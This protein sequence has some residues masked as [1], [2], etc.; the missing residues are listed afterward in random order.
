MF[1]SFSLLAQSSDSVQEDQPLAF[2]KHKLELATELQDGLAKLRVGENNNDLE[3][4]LAACLE[5]ANLYEREKYFAKELTFL[6]QAGFIANE[7]GK[8]EERLEIQTKIA[9]S[10]FAN[11]EWE[12]A[13]DQSEELF[14]QHQIFGQYQPAIN[15]LEKMAESAIKL[16]NYVKAREIYL[17]IMEIAGVVG[18]KPVELTALNNM[19]FASTH[20]EN[21]KEAIHYFN[22][23]EIKTEEDQIKTPGYVFTN[24]GIAWNNLGERDKALKKLR[25]AEKQDSERK[26][27]IQHLIASIYLTDNDIYN[28]LT[29]NELAIESAKK[30]DDK[31][32]MADAY[33]MASQIYQELYEHDK[34][35]D[36]Y[37]K[38]LSLKDSLERVLILEQK[39]LENIHVFMDDTENNIRQSIVESEL[40]QANLEQAEKQNEVIQLQL[41]KE[42]QD[43]EQQRQ[44][45]QIALL[46]K[47]QEAKEASIRT[48][49]LEAD[50]TRQ[51]LALATQTNLAL[52]REQ[53]IEALNQQ[54]QLDSLEAVKRAQAQQQEFEL[55]EKQKEVERQEK[56]QQEFRQ[57]MYT[58]GGL[59][60]LIMAIITGSW[61]YARKLNRELA[62]QNEKI[63]LQ[64]KEIVSERNRAE[65]LLLNILPAAIA[66]ELKEKGVATPQHY[67]AASVLFTDFEGFT[68]IAAT[69]APAQVVEELNECFVKFDQIAEKY[70]LEKIK[71]IGD[72]YMCAGGLPIANKS[73]PMDAVN[74]GK[75][76]LSF[77]SQ[78][79]KRLQA[80]GRLPWPIRIGIHT[81][82]LVA[83]VVGSKKFAYDIW[84]DTVNVASRMESN[85]ESGRINISQATFQLLDN[86]VDCTFRG[87]IDVKNKG[88]MGMYIVEK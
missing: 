4:K 1:F 85:S 50:R 9:K 55:R 65:G 36:F 49:K 3:I 74:A 29:Y 30:L 72:S 11:R 45:Q 31:N 5:L 84:G 78:R 8:D 12:A 2:E 75:E 79:N 77:I 68:A 38:H 21:Y 62:S 25:I 19:G 54:H 34:A 57:Q 48:A 58:L 52:K 41:E 37:K 73:H 26:S 71:T 53:Q 80:E 59:G 51:E 15:D 67:D 64:N 35:L 42:K 81:G 28:A 40:K 46:E 17:K 39:E 7:L 10:Y 27:Y 83:G 66:S 56:E 70:N 47:E 24:L 61:F 6:E 63:E 14:E 23:S 82:E 13:F 16:N 22:Q 60:A 33:G 44:Q 18:D 86:K 69:M 43:L 88:K 32:G 87:E 20:L 76:M